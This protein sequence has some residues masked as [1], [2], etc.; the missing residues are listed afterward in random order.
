MAK[1]KKNT[2]SEEEWV[3]TS[4]LLLDAIFLNCDV[5]LADKIKSDHLRLIYEYYEKES[6]FHE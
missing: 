2:L 5:D 4:G 1:S 6:N 3:I